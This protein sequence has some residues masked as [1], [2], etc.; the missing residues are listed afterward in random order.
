MTCSS[1]TIFSIS[2]RLVGAL[3]LIALVVTPALGGESRVEA[4]R[5]QAAAA[6]ARHDPIA[7]EVPLRAAIRDGVSA[8]ALRA[9]LGQAL[10]ARGE[11][12]EA[13]K[14]LYGGGYSPD[15]AAVGWRI[16]GQLE[17]IDGN[18]PL[19]ARA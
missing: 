6:L 12:T 13:R 16:K 11:R 18:L 2:R 7:A 15:T 14:V 19:A 5:R 8:D 4:L 17:L 3:T 10:L 9:A 1:N